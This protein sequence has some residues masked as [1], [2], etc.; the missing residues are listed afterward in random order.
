MS[1]ALGRFFNVSTAG[2]TYLGMPHNRAARTQYFARLNHDSHNLLP[3]DQ[4]LML[5]VRQLK[6]GF[7]YILGRK[8]AVH[9][10]RSLSTLCLPLS[11]DWR[12][13]QFGISDEGVNMHN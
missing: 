13:G 5:P 7:I 6:R 3:Y 2:T 12:L 10:V 9:V 1:L 8:L 11:L 4:V